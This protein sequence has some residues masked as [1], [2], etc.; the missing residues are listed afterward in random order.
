MS[1]FAFRTGL[2]GAC[3]GCQSCQT[4]RLLNRVGKEKKIDFYEFEEFL[5]P[6]GDDNYS[7]CKG[8]VPDKRMFSIRR[9]PNY[10]PDNGGDDD[11][12]GEDDYS[13]MPAAT[14]PPSVWQSA[15]LQILCQPP[16]H[17]AGNKDKGSLV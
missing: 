15:N 17:W 7:D 6:G 9:C 2:D 4:T 8:S 5:T 10:P 14:I 3:Q 13:D 1:Q 12:D 16:Q 11:R